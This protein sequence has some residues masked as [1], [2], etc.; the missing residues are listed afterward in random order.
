MKPEA[1]HHHS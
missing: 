1:N